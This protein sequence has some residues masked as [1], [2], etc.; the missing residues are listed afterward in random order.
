M[1]VVMNIVPENDVSNGSFM[2]KIGVTRFLPHVFF[3][4]GVCTWMDLK[5]FI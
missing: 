5:L 4:S 1:N 2:L 3:V